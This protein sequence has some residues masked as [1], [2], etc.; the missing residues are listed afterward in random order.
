VVSSTPPHISVLYRTDV[1]EVKESDRRVVGHITYYNLAM[2]HQSLANP[3][4]RTPAMAAGAAHHLWKIEE[5]R[6][7]AWLTE[8]G[9]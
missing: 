2:P 5:D 6:G 7:A 1:R 4:P 3:Y 9:P 8:Y